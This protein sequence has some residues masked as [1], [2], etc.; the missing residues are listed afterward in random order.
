MG[1]GERGRRG[2]R[3]RAGGRRRIG[4][5][6][7]RNR[8]GGGFRNRGTRF[9]GGRSRGGGAIRLKGGSAP[10]VLC[11]L[12]ITFGIFLLIPGLVLLGTGLSSTWAFGGTLLPGIVIVSIAGF[13]LL[14]GIIL[15][16]VL[17]NKD[18]CAC[19]GSDEVVTTISTADIPSAS[20]RTA[21][22]A[23][24][25][26]T[27]QPSNEPPKHVIVNIEYVQPMPG[28]PIPT[29]GDLYPMPPPEL[30]NPANFSNPHPPA[31]DMTY[32]PPMTGH[33]GSPMPTGPD[34]GFSAPPPS[35]DSVT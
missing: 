21:P 13:L 4:G 5:G 28:Q 20:E 15:C 9:R 6:L 3:R 10:A 11:I 30:M 26:G 33:Y 12:S 19:G 22:A 18:S 17:A 23:T 7:R 31:A 2:G 27:D 25:E 1:A 29:S 8:I 32:P 35:Y 14:V 16:I 34:A 24:T